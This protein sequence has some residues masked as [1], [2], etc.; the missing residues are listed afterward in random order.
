MR[1][2]YHFHCLYDTRCCDMQLQ[3]KTE[4]CSISHLDVEMNL[5]QTFC[6]KTHIER[7]G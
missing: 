5:K 4:Y 6:G 3:P 7:T 2:G 1:Q